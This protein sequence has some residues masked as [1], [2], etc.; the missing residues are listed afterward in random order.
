MYFS[1]VDSAT[2]IPILRSSPRMRGEPHN[3]FEM[4]C[5]KHRTV[6]ELD[7]GRVIEIPEVGGLHHRYERRA[8]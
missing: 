5:P 6:H 1:T 7:R 2:T 3:E 4:D 8:A